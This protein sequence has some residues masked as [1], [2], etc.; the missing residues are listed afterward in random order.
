MGDQLKLEGIIPPIATPFTKSG[1]IDFEALKEEARFLA[2]SGV[3]GLVVGGSGG[4]G[5]ALSA[6][7]LRE[8][9]QAVKST[10]REIRGEGF[11]VLAG[12]IRNSTREAIEYAS[13]AREGGA[14]GLQ[15]TPFPVY[16]YK[17]YI[18]DLVEGFREVG[19]TVGLPIVIYNVVPTNKISARDFKKMSSVE[20]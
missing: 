3:N 8:A 12:V 2:S 18:D 7:E 6:Q 5:F 16:L 10:T 15:M 17:P 11:P 19:T 4:E 14:D 20:Q 1:E 9:T 13:A